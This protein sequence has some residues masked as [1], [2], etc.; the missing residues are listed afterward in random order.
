MLE[1]WTAATL[2]EYW[3]RPYPWWRSYNE[4]VYIATLEAHC[5]RCY[6]RS[7]L[8]SRLS[9]A[10]PETELLLSLPP[11][12][13]LN[14][15]NRKV[16][17][18]RTFSQTQ[19]DD[20]LGTADVIVALYRGSQGHIMSRSVCFIRNVLTFEVFVVLLVRRL[21]CDV[22]ARQEGPEAGNPSSS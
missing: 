4:N 13:N 17:K 10:L 21:L 5:L 2:I 16:V 20:L 6:P 8:S 11:N 7:C 18:N 22:N 15:F 3:E 1:D 14:V 12:N 19:S 9:V